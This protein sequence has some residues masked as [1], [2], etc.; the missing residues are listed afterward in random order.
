LSSAGTP[1]FKE[2]SKIKE[3]VKTPFSPLYDS[4]FFLSS[5]DA[6]KANMQQQQQQLGVAVIVVAGRVALTRQCSGGQMILAFYT[7]W[8]AKLDCL[9]KLLWMPNCVD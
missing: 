6:I 9:F 3:A 7:H 8:I 1:T 5:L 2:C 4:S